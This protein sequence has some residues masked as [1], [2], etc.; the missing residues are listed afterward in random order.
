MFLVHLMILISGMALVLLESEAARTMT[1]ITRK[2]QLR[3]RVLVVDD[4]AEIA[5]LIS[6]FL[7][8][9]GGFRVEHTEDPAAALE[10][11]QRQPYD[12]LIVDRFLPGMDGLE[13]LAALRKSR[14]NTPAI[15]ISGDPTVGEGLEGG[16]TAFL[17][18]PFQ[19][20]RLLEEATK[21]MR[22]PEPDPLSRSDAP[23]P[24]NPI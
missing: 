20:S 2:K 3:N 9:T 8:A 12:L 11:F 4:N 19:L 7:E 21:I 10:V 16:D 14:G 23:N 17:A 18:K 13:L 15:L 5:S 1:I 6:D 22:G 24:R